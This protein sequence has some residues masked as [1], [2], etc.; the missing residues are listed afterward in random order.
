M[1]RTDDAHIFRKHNLTQLADEMLLDSTTM[2]TGVPDAAME[3]GSD[4]LNQFKSE[5]RRMP[6]HE[7]LQ[8]LASLQLRIAALYMIQ[9]EETQRLH[10]QDAQN[11]RSVNIEPPRPKRLRS[12]VLEAMHTDDMPHIEEPPMPPV[13]PQLPQQ[14]HNLLANSLIEGSPF[15]LQHGIA[16]VSI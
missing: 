15:Q 5:Y 11:Q 7:R 16:D 9:N 8:H 1:V 12:P 14:D 13:P 4:M 2:V 10:R 6:E 3:L